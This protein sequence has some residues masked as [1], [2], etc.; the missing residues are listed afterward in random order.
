MGLLLVFFAAAS[1]ISVVNGLVGLDA[2]NELHALE[3]EFL[4]DQLQPSAAQ[5]KDWMNRRYWA[6]R[7]SEDL[8]DVANKMKRGLRILF[9]AR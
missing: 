9:V 4:G 5:L 2:L 3:R 6:S 8:G 7:Q 1:S